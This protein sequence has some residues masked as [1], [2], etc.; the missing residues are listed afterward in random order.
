MTMKENK[1]K[2]PQQIA[3]KR[4]EINFANY[5]PRKIS[6]EAKKQLKANLKRIGLLGGVV[7][8]KTTGN[9]VSGHQRVSVMD[10]VNRYESGENDYE[11]RV[12]VVEMDEKTEKEQNIFM[13]NRSVQG[14][15]DTDMLE[16]MLSDI[17]YANAGLDD[18]DLQMLGIGEID[19]S[20]TNGLSWNEEETA[21]ENNIQH[22]SA[23]SKCGEEDKNTDRSVNFYEDTPENQIKRH[24]EIQKIKD[25]ISNQ[26]SDDGGTLSYVVLSFPNPESRIRFMD[27]LGYTEDDKYVD[28]EEFARKIEFGE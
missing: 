26:K 17:D 22:I 2:Q 3:I 4:S 27:G 11:L 12:E 8:N 13:N 5:N 1:I 6:D 28:G 16:N 23:I 7:W 10:E 25:R 20:M 14:E 9:L 18:F 19:E 24:N 15:F 21:K